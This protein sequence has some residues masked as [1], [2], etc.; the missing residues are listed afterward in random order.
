[1]IFKSNKCLSQNMQRCILEDKGN[2]PFKRSYC[3]MVVNI[4][5]VFCKF[6]RSVT[7]QKLTR[8]F[9]HFTFSLPVKES[10]SPSTPCVPSS[11]ECPSLSRPDFWTS[12]VPNKDKWEGCKKEF[13]PG[14]GEM[15]EWR[16][17]KMEARK[18]WGVCR[19]RKW[20]FKINILHL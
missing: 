17:W 3:Q 5:K 10:P 16:F 20:A 14:V 2:S 13:W 11:V 15:S 1:M 9:P 12:D 18:S 6:I 19:K 4:P 8:K 7:K